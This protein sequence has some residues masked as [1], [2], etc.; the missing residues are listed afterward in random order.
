M[1]ELTEIEELKVGESKITDAGLPSLVKLPHLQSLVLVRSKI[2]D[3]GVASLRRLGGLKT[4]TI[5]PGL[6][7]AGA[8][9]LKRAL[10]GCQIQ[11]AESGGGTET[12][13]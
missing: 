7:K 1:C 9:A 6:T 8:T 3:A 10:P 5:G 12:I 2:T 4:L 13:P 11:Y